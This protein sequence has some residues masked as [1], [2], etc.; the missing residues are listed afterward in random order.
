MQPHQQ[1]QHRPYCHHHHFNLFNSFQPSFSAPSTLLPV[2][3]FNASLVLIV[4]HH[5]SHRLLCPIFSRHFPVALFFNVEKRFILLRFS[6]PLTKGCDG[7]NV[8]KIRG[9]TLP[10]I[11]NLPSSHLVPICM[12]ENAHIAYLLHQRD[13]IWPPFKTLS[14]TLCVIFGTRTFVSPN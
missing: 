4:F 7:I 1:T 8:R 2:A 10:H 13:I 14:R 11:F 12:P 9:L 3:D 6:I 5:P